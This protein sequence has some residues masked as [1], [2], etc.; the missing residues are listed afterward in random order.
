[1][2]RYDLTCEQ[3]HS[4]DGWFQSADVFDSLKASGHVV[5]TRCGSWDVSKALMAPAVASRDTPPMRI[6]T[7]R[8]TK[9]HALAALRAKV[10]A[11]SD[12]VGPNFAA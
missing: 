10:E 12:Y 7:P 8:D 9:E 2:I 3:G 5:C 6:T 11:E 1:M 4:F